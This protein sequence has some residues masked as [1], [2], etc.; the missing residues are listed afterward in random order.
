MEVERPYEARAGPNHANNES[1]KGAK[2]SRGQ[3]CVQCSQRKVKCDRN[4]P[5]ANCVKAKVECVIAPPQPRK[6]RK[7][8]L[9]ERELVERLR[10]C[11]LLLG[12][13]GIQVETDPRA[14]D[15]EVKMGS[16]P[17]PGQ[18][19]GDQSALL[20]NESTCSGQNS[21]AE[22]TPSKVVSN[23]KEASPSSSLANHSG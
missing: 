15:L 17:G 23:S 11:E 5:C 4:K 14:P 2:V 13:N 10:R 18:H 12:Q 21:Y 6:R 1:S 19:D 8:K 16:S 9:T 22:N 20:D 7:Q 3:S